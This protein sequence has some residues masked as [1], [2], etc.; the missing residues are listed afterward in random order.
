MLYSPAM[1]PNFWRRVWASLPRRASSRILTALAFVTIFLG[2]L[3]AQVTPPPV[4]ASDDF[5]RANLDPSRWTFVNPLGDGWLAMTGNNTADAYL[6]LYVP[7][8]Q[9]HDPWQ[10][11]NRSVRAM[12]VAPDTDFEVE[13]NFDSEPDPNEAYQLQGIIIEESSSN[14]L[15]FDVYSTGS[16][17]KVF[18]ASTVNGSSSS[19]INLTINPGDAAYLKVTRQGNSWTYAYSADGSAWTQAGSFVHAMA[20]DSVGPFAANHSQGVN[21]APA[22]TAK[23]DY[24]FNTAAPIVPEDNGAEPDT[25]APFIHTIQPLAAANSLTITWYT[26]EPAIGAVDLGLTTAYGTTQSESSA[27]YFHSVTFSGMVAGNTYHYQIRSADNLNQESTSQDFT[28]TFNPAGPDIDIWYGDTQ[29]FGQIGNPQELWINVFGHV[30]D[31]D[32]MGSLSYT[33]NGGSPVALSIGPDNRR[34]ENPGDFNIDLNWTTLNNGAN[35]V[36]ITAT[37]ALSNVSTKTVTVNYTAGNVWPIPYTAD[38]SSLTTDAD[39]ATPDPQIQTL[40]QVVDGKW[41]VD[42]GE[43]RTAEPGYDR[44]VAIG[45]HL[46][47]DYEALVPITIHS[48]LAGG[49]G[50]GLLFRWN[51]HTNTPV[52]CPQPLCG[53]EPLGA[54]GWF[55]SN[56]LEFYQGVSQSVTV[57]AGTTYWMRMRVENSGSNPVYSLKVWEDGQAEPA[58][59]NLTQTE[60][61]TTPQSGSLLL[62]AH[63]ADASFGTVVVTPVPGTPNLPPEAN[64]DIATVVTA[65]TTN[66]N[67]LSNDS[68]SDG[69]LAPVTVTV[70]D[71]PDHGIISSINP[72]TGIITY[73]HDGSA[74]SSDFFTYTVED[75]D[76]AVS[77]VAAVNISVSTTPVL[78]FV[79]DDFFGGALDPAWTFVDPQSDGTLQFSGANTADAWAEISVPA[80]PEHQLWE[81]GIQAPHLLQPAT[82]TDLEI[83]V[84]FESPVNA[85]PYQEQGILIKQDDFNF[86]RFEV[87][88]NNSSTMVLAGIL[89]SGTNTFPLSTSLPINQSISSLNLAPIYLR[90]QRVGNTWTQSYS[91]DGV[92]FTT[93]GNTINHQ[94]TVTA[95]GVYAGNG[96]GNNAPAHTAQIDYFENVLDDPIT[97]EDNVSANFPLVWGDVSARESGQDVMIAWETIVERNND[98]FAVERMLPEG[99]FMAVGQVDGVGTSDVPQ[100]YTFLD[101]AVPE[102]TLFYRIRQVDTDGA[103]SY[104]PTI[105]IL[106]Q[107]HG[108]SMYPVP[109]EDYVRIVLPESYRAGGTL[110]LRD[111]QGAEIYRYDFDTHAAF[112]LNVGK[113]PRGVYL[114]E[115]V[116]HHGGSAIRRLVLCRH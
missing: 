116:G 38:W 40:A 81:D 36:V 79:S 98:F 20:V 37:D 3:S 22:F 23:V 85:P 2:P 65:G 26:D 12:Q 30:S 110:I 19:K 57:T 59:W 56:K 101:Q 78:S 76:G 29:D 51:G 90:V 82:N 24:F 8:G 63:E 16:A 35:T 11:Q 113:Q 45:D 72:S 92:N 67:V 111:I 27:S 32:G 89:S 77:N 9:S 41:S 7:A 68:D 1:L 34:L 70:V 88:S 42:N 80:G 108:F 31:P 61:P 87:Y 10:A 50:V 97:T 14:W 100:T 15:R 103:F 75:N 91:T 39:P 6:E 104:S 25:L 13:V 49:F 93:V 4:V 86:L 74:T 69:L 114:V 21:N 47:D 64:D 44:L 94:M 95:V 73:D 66:I 17:L 43:I 55:R 83:V 53:Y 84:K 112:T 46:S 33:L 96:V 99:T 106:H 28:F 48:T 58:N 105:E 5:D 54:I 18:A 115:L 62:I 102:G 71:P 60:G 52:T 107:D 109:A